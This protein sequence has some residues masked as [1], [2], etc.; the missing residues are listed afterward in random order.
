MF[1]YQIW[2]CKKGN[3]YMLSWK[4]VTGFARNVMFIETLSKPDIKCKKKKIRGI[5]MSRERETWL[6][7]WLG[8]GF[9][10]VHVY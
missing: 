4:N 2:M 8:W 5:E 9:C 6:L 1:V 10:N 3:V 7:K